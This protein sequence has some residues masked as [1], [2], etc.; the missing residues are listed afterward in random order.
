MSSAIQTDAASPRERL[1]QAR[2]ALVRE[3]I[4]AAALA[5]FAAFGYESAK[6]NDIAKRAGVSLAAFYAA[7]PSKWEVFRALHSEMLDALMREVGARVVAGVD[8]FDRLRLGL[9]GYLRFHM[10]HPD[11]L[12]VQLRERVPW[13]T[14][15][16][17]RTP[18]QTRAWE[19]G[20]VMLTAAF[21]QGMDDGL[22]VPDD[23][24]LC[25]R[26]ATAMGQVRLVVWI[27]NE[28]R[29]AADAVADSANR[30]IVRT[31]ARPERV[32]ELL[33]RL[34]RG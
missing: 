12:R 23:P 24:V 29:E 27:G 4:V 31:F 3:A 25:A 26:T 11:F 2:K 1:I 13:G 33:A 19:A 15:D 18:E 5:E 28:M 10:Q 30:Q 9:E 20:L 22:L 17:L 6:V 21:R 8:A 14:T 32:V 34:D 7:F 16:E